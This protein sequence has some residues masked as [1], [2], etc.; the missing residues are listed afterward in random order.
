MVENVPAGEHS[1]NLTFTNDPYERFA[2]LS[3]VYVHSSNSLSPS[4]ENSE[5]YG[6]ISDL[7]KRKNLQLSVQEA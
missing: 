6:H 7:E 5:L 2:Y 3:Q 4:A 1:F